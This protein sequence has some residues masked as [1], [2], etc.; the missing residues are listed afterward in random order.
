MSVC[1][2]WK[3]VLRAR[4]RASHRHRTTN[5]YLLQETLRSQIVD[6]SCV[7]PSCVLV[8]LYRAEHRSPRYA[9]VRTRVPGSD[10]YTTFVMR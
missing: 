2:S 8:E 7:V 3:A 9:R 4:G 6:F 1:P 10:T 5:Y